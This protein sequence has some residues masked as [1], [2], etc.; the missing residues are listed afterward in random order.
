MGCLATCTSLLPSASYHAVPIRERPVG[1][2]E[3]SQEAWGH[4]DKSQYNS[5]TFVKGVIEQSDSID[6]IKKKLCVLCGGG[7]KLHP[8]TT[9]YFTRNMVDYDLFVRNVLLMTDIL[10]GQTKDIITQKLIAYMKDINAHT[11][12]IQ[13]YIQSSQKRRH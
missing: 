3:D 9:F 2:V 11:S 1:P 12:M 10:D 4:L 8:K 5:V 6:A 7:K 13:K